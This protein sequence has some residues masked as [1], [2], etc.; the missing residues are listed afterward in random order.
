M[1]PIDTLTRLPDQQDFDRTLI[2]KSDEAARSGSSLSLLMIDVDRL[3]RHNDSFGHN[4]GDQCLRKIAIAILDSVQDEEQSVARVGGDEFAVILPSIDSVQALLI[5]DNLRLL[6]ATLGLPCS[7]GCHAT[8]TVS[9]GA[10]TM[11]PNNPM[12]SIELIAAADTALYRAK[13]AGRNY[14]FRGL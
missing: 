9:I 14:V 3:E 1:S 10:A 8:L 13:Q 12:S 4:S 2:I 11:S 5:A 7:Q 6:V